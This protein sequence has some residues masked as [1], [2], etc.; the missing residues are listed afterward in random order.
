MTKFDLIPEPVRQRKLVNAN[1]AFSSIE[2]PSATEVID[3][4]VMNRIAVLLAEYSYFI[5]SG[6]MTLRT[7]LLK[8]VRDSEDSDFVILLRGEDIH[9]LGMR[10]HEDGNWP[11]RQ[12]RLIEVLN[13]VSKSLDKRGLLE[14]LKSIHIKLS[15]TSGAQPVDDVIIFE[16]MP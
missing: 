8:W 9:E 12:S 15:A 14:V 5:R 11:S 6:D 7:V 2:Y 16:T 4:L 10:L 3:V 13:V 1:A